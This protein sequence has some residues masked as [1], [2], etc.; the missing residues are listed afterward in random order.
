M[1]TITSQ[2]NWLTATAILL[3]LPAAFLILIGIL[4][5]FGITG[6]ME[7]IQPVAEYWGIKDPPGLNITSIILFGPMLALLL[8][9]FQFLKVEWRF[10]SEEFLLNLSFQKRWFPVLVAAAS[11]GVLAMLSLY[12]FVENCRC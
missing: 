6:P 3:L 4:S 12:M 1:K 10:S 8:T 7:T 2:N 11:I 5:A 9:I